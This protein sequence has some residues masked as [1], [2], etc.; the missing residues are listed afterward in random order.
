M[1]KQQTRVAIIAGVIT[2]ALTAG[3]LA[4]CGQKAKE[5]Y[6]DARRTG[7]ENSQP[8]DLIRNADGFSNLSTKCDHGNRIYVV[9]HGDA[10]YSA[11]AVVPEDPTCGNAP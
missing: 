11:I 9:F 3:G 5:P 6:Q 4:A 2:A 1:N 7:V 10:A 8:V